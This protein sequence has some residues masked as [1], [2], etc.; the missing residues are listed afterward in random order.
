MLIG[1]QNA[2]GQEEHLGET[3]HYVA[4]L[5]ACQSKGGHALRAYGYYVRG[6]HLHGAEYLRR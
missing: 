3:P 2:G 5:E 4:F 6:K 1:S